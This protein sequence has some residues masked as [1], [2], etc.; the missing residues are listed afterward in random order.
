MRIKTFAILIVALGLTVFA[1]TDHFW[2]GKT[3]PLEEI[4]KRWGKI[5]LDT[6]TFRNGN[7]RMRASMAYSLVKNQK[8][9]KDK[10]VLDIRKEF[11]SPDGFYFSDTF[12]AY[13]IQTAKSKN[14]E[15]WQIVFLL[16]KDR[17]VQKIIVH[18]N[19]CN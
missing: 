8:Q 5:E 18:K 2:G 4:G 17:K 6:E 11:G 12:P 9:F 1:A 7:E 3:L 10:F 15:A 16:D 19:C 14:E 13:L